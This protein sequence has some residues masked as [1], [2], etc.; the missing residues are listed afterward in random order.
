MKAHE[1]TAAL[2]ARFQAEKVYVQEEIKTEHNFE[3]IIGQS[4][5][6]RQLLR[7][8]EQVAPTEASVLILGETG[9][10][11]ELL[12][13]AVHDRSQR[14]DRPL[15]KVNCGSIPSGLVESELFGHEK[16]AFTGATQRR[17]GRF[18][19]AHGGTIF[20]DE[21][22]ELPL[23]TPGQTPPCFAGGGVRARR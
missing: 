9:T 18:E 21:V 8:L 7:E 20:L 16:G 22:L 14:K 23:D 15:V 17:I 12:A 2:K 19:L 11:K 1:E 6:V 5:P 13:R 4:A 3:E 10:V